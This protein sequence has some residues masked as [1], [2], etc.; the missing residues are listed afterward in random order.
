[1]L[2]RCRATETCPKIVET[3]GSAEFFNL[4]ASPD[5]VGTRADRDIPLPANVR[6]YYFPGVG[7]GGGPGGFDPDS[8]PQACCD[9]PSNPNP[10]SDTLRALQTALVD[11]VVKGA[12]PPPSH[13]PRLDRGELTSPTQAAM[14]FPAIPGAPLPDGVLTPLYQYDLGPQFHYNDLS[15]VVTMQPP[16]IRQILPT[17]VPRVDA[18]GNEVAGVASVLHQVPLGTYTGWNTNASGFYKGRIRTNAGG[19]VPF[20]KTKVERLA[21]GDPRPSL[22]E[23]Y[24]THEKYVEKVRAAAERLVRGRFLLQSDAD[25]LIS[26]AEASKVLK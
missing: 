7:H 24:G 10:S 11:W 25:R 22:E 18:D 13:Y 1:L 12:L 9:L 20:A 14:G 3:F 26:Q 4:R 15:G 21:S 23:R 6:R 17:V 8:K 16:P 5:L 19:F 2:G